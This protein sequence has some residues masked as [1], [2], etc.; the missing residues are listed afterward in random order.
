MTRPN[1]ELVAFTKE[2]RA[3]VRGLPTDLGRVVGVHV[4]RGDAAA[5]EH[6]KCARPP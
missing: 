2:L 4:R 6:P 5:R 3:D 1:D